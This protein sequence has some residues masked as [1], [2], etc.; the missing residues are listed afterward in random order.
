LLD[1]LGASSILKSFFS[2]FPW[3]TNPKLKGSF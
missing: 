3:K 2:R 1:P